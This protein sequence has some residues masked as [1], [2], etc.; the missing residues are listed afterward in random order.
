MN[1]GSQPDALIRIRGMTRTYR[2]G[3]T[4]IDALSGID[5]DIYRNED[6]AIM[7]PSGSGKTTLMNMI[8]C[9]ESPT[10][11]SSLSDIPDVSVPFSA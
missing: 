2:M 10:S 4:T 5:L 11:A 6:V 3:E 8:G 7:G 9:L 1:T